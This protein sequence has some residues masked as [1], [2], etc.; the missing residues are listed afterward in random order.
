[1][2]FRIILLSTFALLS[3]SGAEDRARVIWDST[4]RPSRPSSIRAGNAHPLPQAPGS[5]I[6][7]LTLW[8]CR[9][10]RD[11]D[12]RE[13]RLLVQDKA[14]LTVSWIPERIGT[15]TPLSRG[16]RIRMSIEVSEPGF[17]YIFDRER[18]RGGRT[19][20]PY[21]IY[22][23]LNMNGGGNRAGPGRLI[24]I[25]PRSD[26]S[27]WWMLSSDSNDYAGELISIV[28]SAHPLTGIHIREKEVPI[29]ETMFHSIWERLSARAKHYDLPAISGKAPTAA[30]QAA[31]ENGRL[32]TQEDAPPQ[33][34]VEI[35][36]RR[37]GGY[38]FTIPLLL[39]Q[40]AR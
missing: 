21:L 22:P 17:L 10:W 32:L 11:G 4:M 40:E 23:N 33:T 12:P 6:V 16:D 3:S 15:Q 1:M 38:A 29:S 31:G 8:R 37:P 9:P 30:E 7:G 35:T 36:G 39:K 26:S 14:G 20:R 13:G 19:G 18:Y 34:I 27:P 24:E 2:K 5:G 28:F 25:P